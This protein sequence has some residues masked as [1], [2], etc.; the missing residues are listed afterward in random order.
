MVGSAKQAT[1]R[2]TVSARI[3]RLLVCR[4]MLAGTKKHKVQYKSIW[5]KFEKKYY[6]LV[7]SAAYATDLIKYAPFSK[8]LHLTAVN[9]NK[10][11]L[12]VRY[13]D[14]V[15]L[16]MHFICDQ[17]FT[18]PIN[19]KTMQKTQFWCNIS[20]KAVYKTQLSILQLKK[21][22]WSCF[23]PTPWVRHINFS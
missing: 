6:R 9:R 11:Q 13:I 5:F 23:N 10:D 14:Q 21:S 8:I 20:L 17:P 3:F 12:S 2:L 15:S 7:Q 4:S 19:L 22:D 16:Q 18:I 1:S